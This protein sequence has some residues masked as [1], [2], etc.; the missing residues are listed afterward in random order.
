M[1]M[2]DPKILFDDVA[3]LGDLFISFDFAISQFSRC[4]VFA[5]DAI[6]NFVVEEKIP[7]GQTGAAFIGIHPVKLPI[8]TIP[9]SL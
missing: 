3:H 2:A 8:D 7:V 1:K 5:H 4:G 6:G 9:R